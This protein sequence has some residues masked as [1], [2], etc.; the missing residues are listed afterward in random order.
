MDG[1]LYTIPDLPVLRLRCTLRAEQPSRL[2]GF[3]GS[4]LRGA[5]GHALRSLVC[6][7][8]PA[9]ACAACSLRV[10]CHYTNLFETFVEGEPPPLLK[11]LETAPRPYVFEAEDDRRDFAPGDRLDFDLLLVGSA[12]QLQAL[13]AVAVD[14]MAHRGLT[15]RRHRFQLVQASTREADGFRVRWT[16]DEPRWNGM[17]APLLPRTDPL[18]GPVAG[19]RFVTPTRLKADGHLEARIGF[20]GLVFRMLRRTLELAHFF[21]DPAAIDWDFQEYLRLASTIRT[22][23]QQF[24][25]QDVKRYSSRQQTEMTLGGFLGTLRL[26]GDLAPFTKLLRT[27]EVVHVGKGATFGLGRMEV[28]PGTAGVPPAE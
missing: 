12:G 24:G 25:W 28:V 1:D 22:V 9:Q 3:K 23:D 21:A 17:A 16:R 18:P 2:P 10:P 14:R 8:G 19:L 27:A 7:M 13:A 11:G 5:F 4:M 20:R 15:E 26:E 6:V